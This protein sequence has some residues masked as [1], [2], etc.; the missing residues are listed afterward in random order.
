MPDPTVIPRQPDRFLTDEQEAILDLYN[1]RLDEI[2]H[3]LK[4]S[5]R[6]QVEIETLHLK[7]ILSR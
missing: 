6:V 7:K 5:E 3:E 1:K 4:E 2:Y